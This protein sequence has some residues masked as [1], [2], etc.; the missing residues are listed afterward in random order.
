MPTLHELQNDVAR[1][2]IGRDTAAAA[3]HVVGD[4]LAPAARLAVYRNTIVAGLTTALRLSYP[5]VHRLVG[6]AFFESAAQLFLEARPPR[7]ACLD[8]YD[9]G[10]ADFLAG[11][12]PAA[13][14]PYLAGVA[15]FDWAVSRALHAPDAAA[16]DPAALGAV[17]A[18]DEKRL[19]LVPHP[20][21]GLVRADHPVDAIWRAVLAQ[22]D[23]AMAA[24]DLAAGPVFLRVRRDAGGGA[25]IA[26]LEPASW[27]FTASL[28]AGATLHDAIQAA[29]EV[30]AAT[31][32]ATHLIDGVFTAFTVG[33]ADGRQPMETLP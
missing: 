32:L 13:A 25:D 7:A 1:G 29:G 19:R 4:G 28:C 15:R 9:P 3:L 18:A 31:L 2:L 14:I 27:R 23:A 20:S 11:F 12:A 26:R 33:D 30:D 5:A 8:D 17:D 21:V 16:L 6:A 24:I 10:F 22:D